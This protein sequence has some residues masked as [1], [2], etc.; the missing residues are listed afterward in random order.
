MRL[1][2]LPI[3]RL[4]RKMSFQEKLAFKQQ[5]KKKTRQELKV[6]KCNRCEALENVNEQ[7]KSGIGVTSLCLRMKREFFKP[8]TKCSNAKLK[9]D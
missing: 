4:L 5:K 1:A 7:L 6:N 8:I 2:R 3:L 9:A